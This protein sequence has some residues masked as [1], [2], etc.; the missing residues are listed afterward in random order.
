MAISVDNVYQTVQ[1]ILNVEQRGQ[2][3]PADFNHFA[4][5]AQDE[6][7]ANLFYDKQHFDS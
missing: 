3:S 2:F 4:K 1:R 7:F 6:L 5:L